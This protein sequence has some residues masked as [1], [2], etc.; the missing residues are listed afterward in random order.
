VRLDNFDGYWNQDFQNPGL[1]NIT[2]HFGSKCLYG[3]TGKVG[4]GKSG[5]LAAIL[6]EVPYYS[7]KL[8]VRGSIA[9]VEQEPVIFSDTVK[10]NIIYGKPFNQR[11]YNEAIRISCLVSDLQLFQKGDQTMVG[12]KGITLSGGQ[13]TRLSLARAIYADADIY[14]MDDP[15][16]AV[17]AKVAKEICEKCFKPLSL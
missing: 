9:Y 5:L 11:L 14:I 12:E 1:K 4:S 13:K 3:I 10:N 2:Y 16:S 17:D 8:E 7:G 15:I 6:G